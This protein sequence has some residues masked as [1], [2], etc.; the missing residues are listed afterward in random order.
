M[1]LLDRIKADSGK[2]ESSDK[3]YKKDTMDDFD[4]F[5]DAMEEDDRAGAYMALKS[6]IRACMD[7]DSEPSDE[8][9]DEESGSG[10][11][12]GGLAILLGMG[13]KK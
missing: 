4:A 5:A 1:A 13:K 9:S 3:S 12:P 10:K 7:E 8:E 2:E 6:M 11:K